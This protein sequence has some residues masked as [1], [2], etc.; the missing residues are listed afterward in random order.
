MVQEPILVLAATGGQ[1]GAVTD[2]L[3]VRGSG[4]G[5]WSATRT[6]VPHGSWQTGASRWSRVP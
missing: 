3:L 4:S 1:G 5:R 6:A 2:A